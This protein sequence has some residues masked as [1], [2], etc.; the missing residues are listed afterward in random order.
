MLTTGNASGSP[1]TNYITKGGYLY[2]TR[3]EN[4]VGAQTK[5]FNK[6][7]LGVCYKGGL[8]ERE[9]RANTRTPKQKRTL[10]GLL[11]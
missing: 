7:S 5:D 4:L 6:H 10:L 11:H 1:T 8:D 2:Q 9:E 3:H